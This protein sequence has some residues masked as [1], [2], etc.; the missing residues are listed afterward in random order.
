MWSINIFSC[1]SFYCRVLNQTGGCGAKCHNN[2]II[3]QIQCNVSLVMI[4][5]PTLFLN[6]IDLKRFKAS[7]SSAH[8]YSKLSTP[9]SIPH[10]LDVSPF[11]S[12]ETGKPSVCNST[13]KCNGSE[14]VYIVACACVVS[15]AWLP[16]QG[17]AVID[18]C[19]VRIWTAP[20]AIYY[21]NCSQ[22]DLSHTHSSSLLLALL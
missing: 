13:F 15:M 6:V 18:L 17:W 22:V 9:V 11:A 7:S 21:N 3:T 5:H 19:S 2:I 16:I 4:H 1:A 10:K 8:E 20:L 14:W 12:P